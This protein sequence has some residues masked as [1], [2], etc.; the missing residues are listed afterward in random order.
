MIIQNR[1]AGLGYYKSKI[2]GIFGKDTQNS[3]KK[4]KQ[5]N[6]LKGQALWDIQIQKALFKGSGL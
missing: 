6:G 5:D 2:N 3:I 1:L 4:Y